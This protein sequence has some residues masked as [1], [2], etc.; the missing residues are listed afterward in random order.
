ME[1]TRQD[2]QRLHWRTLWIGALV[3]P[4][5]SYWISRIEVFVYKGGG[6][7]TA[8]LIWTSVYN[9]TLL[10]L[11]SRALA[12]W[13]PKWAL[14]QGDLLAIFAMCNIAA[15]VSGHDLIQI[16]VPLIAYPQWHPTPENDWANI[17]LPYI[18]DWV[19]VT[20]TPAL[21]RYYTGESTLYDPRHLSAWA[22]PMLMWSAFIAVLLTVALGVNVL[23]RKQWTEV[24]RLSYPVVQLPLHLSEPTRS[25][26]K[27]PMLWAG[28]GFVG[29]IDTV[30]NVNRI[31][32]SFPRVQLSYN[33]G[34]MFTESPWNAVGWL[35][36]NVNFNYIG[37][38]YFVPLDILFSCWFFLLFFKSQT[39][40]A[41]AIGTRTLSGFPYSYEQ[42][43]GGYLALGFIALWL[44]RKHLRNIALM[45]WRGEKS[46]EATE[47]RLAVAAIIGGMVFLALFCAYI[48]MPVW[49]TLAFFGLWY[50]IQVAIARMRAEI[51]TPLH[52]LHFGGPSTILTNAFGSARFRNATLAGLTQMWGIDRAYRSDA[53]P[54]QL[55]AF[56][57]QQRADGNRRMFVYALVLASVLAGPYAFWAMLHQSYEVGVHNAA[58]VNLWFGFEAWARFQS[59]VTDRS[60]GNVASLAF[61]GVGFVMTMLLMLGRVKY[62]W[63]PFHPLSYAISGSWQMNWAWGTF[64]IIW[65]VKFVILRFSGIQGYQRWQGFF[66]GLLLGDVFVGGT[67]TMVGIGFNLW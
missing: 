34:P 56:K 59:W 11:A 12:K 64:L 9:M 2:P 45:L 57:L 47:Y 35:P 4:V 6:G 25:F 17:L 37:L 13:K 62:L 38:G 21:E 51:G 27:N 52:D 24:D 55:E 49:V 63:W 41:K 7:S 28:F 31:F 61:T 23:V 36:F 53:V 1:K 40:I 44:T 58:P 67:W 48:G 18:P 5:H 3:M 32:P 54:H 8:S 30:N 46:S 19:T 65:F 10:M 60:G 16:L 26:F 39:V 20:D 66:L 14:N 50:L 15:A 42:S 22:M 29:L 43:S 33:L